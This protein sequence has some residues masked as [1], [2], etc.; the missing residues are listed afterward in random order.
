MAI[1]TK[2]ISFS[3]DWRKG[4]VGRNMQLAAIKNGELWNY[5]IHLPE[6]LA[7]IYT[8]I[9]NGDESSQPRI[10]RVPQACVICFLAI[11]YQST[12]PIPAELSSVTA[13]VIRPHLFD[14]IYHPSL[15]NLV[16]TRRRK[17]KQV[18]FIF[19]SLHPGQKY[20]KCYFLKI[21]F[22]SMEAPAKI[23]WEKYQIKFTP[24]FIS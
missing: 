21:A 9:E 4:I 3:S 24:C 14:V 2:Q 1:S 15:T 18:L 16:Q 6:Y 22:T 23:Y 5:E 19:I 20:P 13:V 8:D 10:S 11:G 17:M 12:V 7:Y